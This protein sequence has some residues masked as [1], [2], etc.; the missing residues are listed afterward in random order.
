MDTKKKSTKKTPA[1]APVK[2]PQPAKRGVASRKSGRANPPPSGVE[3]DPNESYDLQA[4]LEKDDTVYTLDKARCIKV[5][6]VTTQT[7]ELGKSNFIIRQFFT[8]P[9]T[10]QAEAS[11]VTTKYC[12]TRGNFISTKEHTVR[13]ENVSR[14]PI[15]FMATTANCTDGGFDEIGA[16]TMLADNVMIKPGQSKTFK[17]DRMNMHPYLYEDAT[18]RVNEHIFDGYVRVPDLPPQ[19]QC[20]IENT[21]VVDAGGNTVNKQ[22]RVWSEEAEIARISVRTQ[23]LA[24]TAPKDTVPERVAS[25]PVSF[26]SDFGIPYGHSVPTYLSQSGRVMTRATRATRSQFYDISGEGFLGMG[27]A[28]LDDPYADTTVGYLAKFKTPTT[29]QKALLGLPPVENW[30]QKSDEEKETIRE[31]VL[32]DYPAYRNAAMEDGKYSIF[33]PG[34]VGFN[35]DANGYDLNT[36]SSTFRWSLEH[37][38]FV[39]WDYARGR[40]MYIEKGW[41]I[42]NYYSEWVACLPPKGSLVL[43]DPTD[44]SAILL[45]DQFESKFLMEKAISWDLVIFAITVV[46]EVIKGI[47]K[48]SNEMRRTAPQG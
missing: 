29:T 10:R 34:S 9:K 14:G 27:V 42:P 4:N 41:A 2:A 3:V 18:G 44:V 47:Q 43:S 22:K 12:D 21:T 36:T 35:Y 8:R 5:H 45:N 39:L 40:P 19:D 7:R 33:L 46:I 1:K 24:Q 38:A 13:V 28:F 25:H 26:A 16:R 30:M 48:I 17:V 23:Y 31:K 32:S 6:E 20:D 37:M 15:V 11:G